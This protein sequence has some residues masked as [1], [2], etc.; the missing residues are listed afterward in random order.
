MKERKA[1]VY[2]I[3]VCTSITTVDKKQVVR[4]QHI[5]RESV[6][7]EREDYDM[8]LSEKKVCQKK[9]RE[10]ESKND[11]VCPLG[12]RDYS[13]FRTIAERTKTKPERNMQSRVAITVTK[14]PLSGAE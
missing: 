12:Q 7:W 3:P 10:G 14:V 13:R 2:E 4:D 11:K 1:G 6:R 5:S 9:T 8:R